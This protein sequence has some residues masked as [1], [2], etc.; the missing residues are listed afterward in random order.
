MPELEEPR[1]HLVDEAGVAGG[2]FGRGEFV[3]AAADGAEVAWVLAEPLPGGAGPEARGEEVRELHVDVEGCGGVLG[4]VVGIGEGHR[5]MGVLFEG[6]L[7][8]G[9]DFGAAGADAGPAGVE[10]A[11]EGFFGAHGFGGG[12]RGGCGVP[13]AVCGELRELLDEALVVLAGVGSARE[14]TGEEGELFDSGSGLDEGSTFA[15]GV[16]IEEAAEPGGVGGQGPEARL[17]NGR[18]EMSRSASSS[19]R[20]G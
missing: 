2:A 3:E 1:G 19:L 9:E 20:A 13:G 8:G 18:S 6:G 14:G 15:A 11:L 5:E 12:C 16:E 17:T 10:A 4:T 7:G